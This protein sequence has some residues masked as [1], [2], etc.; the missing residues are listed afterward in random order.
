M[1][2]NHVHRWRR[3]L[4][5]ESRLHPTLRHVALTLSVDMEADGTDGRPGAEL[6]ANQCGL[7]A[8]TVRSALTSLCAE[9]W[10]QLTEEGGR[11][12]AVRSPNV[13]R[14]VI[15]ASKVTH[16]DDG[17][18]EG[19]RELPP[20][21]SSGTVDD[22][23]SDGTTPETPVDNVKPFAVK[24]PPRQVKSFPKPNAK[25]GTR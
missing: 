7:T 18:S 17:P 22:S 25:A 4:I 9:G 24:P 19:S 16:V 11:K 8:K 6:L 14:A 12:G 15:P 1:T 13:Y 20:S 23:P 10:L 2:E 21:G 5:N 3:R